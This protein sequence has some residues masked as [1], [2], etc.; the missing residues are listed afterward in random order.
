[1]TAQMRARFHFPHDQR[2]TAPRL[3]TVRKATADRDDRY[4]NHLQGLCLTLLVGTSCIHMVLNSVIAG[5]P[6]QPLRRSC[7]PSSVTLEPH[8]PYESHIVARTG[9]MLQ[10]N[11]SI[12]TSPL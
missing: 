5:V 4:T 3:T 10:I 8:R 6:T 9:E 7:F 12:Q 2:A 11:A 1:M